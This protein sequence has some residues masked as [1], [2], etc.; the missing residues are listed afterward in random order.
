MSQLLARN[1]AG[2]KQEKEQDVCGSPSIKDKYM[3][4]VSQL[5]A[6][7]EERRDRL[8]AWEQ[9]VKKFIKQLQAKTE[10]CAEAKGM[11]ANIASREQETEEFIE[12]LQGETEVGAKA[13]DIR[14]R[15]AVI[16][17]ATVVEKQQDKV[18]ERNICGG[19]KESNTNKAIA[20]K[21]KLSNWEE[22]MAAV[23]LQLVAKKD[24]W[25]RDG[26]GKVGI[27]MPGASRSRSRAQQRPQKG[28]LR[29]EG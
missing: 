12:Q 20:V 5:S 11:T 28:Q 19:N 14:A 27:K 25:V 13:K 24:L 2:S 3:T 23:V 18:K 9:E 8:A 1:E 10:L 4:E 29:G 7:A 16:K 17:V 22:L 6:M 21:K 15:L 26:N